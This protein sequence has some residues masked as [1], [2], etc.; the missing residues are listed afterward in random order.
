MDTERAPELT[1]EEVEAIREKNRELAARMP[2]EGRDLDFEDECKRDLEND[3]LE[4]W[5]RAQEEIKP[6][7]IPKD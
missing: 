1:P 6:P 3:D 2:F 4:D 5:V 7:A